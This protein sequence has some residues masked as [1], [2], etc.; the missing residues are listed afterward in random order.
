ML[1]QLPGV[2]GSAKLFMMNLYKLILIIAGLTVSLQLSAQNIG[3]NE[4]GANPHASAILDVSSVNK[5]MLV[6]RMSTAQRLAIPAPASGLLVYDTSTASFWFFDGTVWTEL[7]SGAIGGNTLDQAYDEGGP[8]AGSTIIANS[9]SVRIFGTDGIIV[10]GQFNSGEAIGSPGPGVRMFFNPRKAAFRSGRINTFQWDEVNVGNYSAAMGENVVASGSHAVAFGLNNTSSG[11]RSASFGWNTTSSGT[12]SMTWGQSTSATTTAAT[13]WG[14]S[15]EASGTNSTAWGFQTIASGNTSTAFGNQVTAPSL[16]EIAI[17]Q[18]N[19]EYTP[20]SA[21]G[22]NAA[23]RLFVIGN[24]TSNANRQNAVTVLKGG[25]VGIGTAAPSATLHIDGTLRIE[26]G[27]EAAGRVLTS[28]ANGNATWVDPGS[29]GVTLDQA[30]DFGGTG[31]GRV[32][33]ADAGAVSVQGTD[34]ME[35]TGTFNSGAAIGNPGAGTRMFFNPRKSAFRAGTVSGAQWNNATVGNYSAAFGQNTRASGEASF[36]AGSGSQANSNHSIALGLNN[37][38]GSTGAI[39]IGSSNIVSF[40]G[41]IALGTGHSVGSSYGVALGFEHTLSGTYASAMGFQNTA[42]GNTAMSF[43]YETTASANFATA[44]GN[45]TT[46]S[47]NLSTAFGHHTR[48]ESFTSFVVGRYN[49][50]GGSATAWV[51]TDPIFEVGIG[52]MPT[53]LNNAL[54]VLKNGNTGIGTHTPSATLHVDGSVRIENG[55][56]AAGHVLTSDADGNATWTALPASG[57]TLD[58]AYDFGGAGAGRII[59]AD[60][61]AVWVEGND[62]F[63]VSG[64]FASGAVIGNPG[65]GTRM[66]FNPR[67]A[68]FRAGNVSGNQWNGPNVGDYSAAFGRSNTASGE[69]SF[70][71]GNSNIASGLYSVTLGSFNGSSGLGSVTI[72]QSN[73]ADNIAAFA[74][75]RE[76]IAS[77]VA[78]VA[79]GE[80]SNA[81]GDFSVALGD[82]PISNGQASVSMGSSTIANGNNSFASGQ[83]SIANG[84]SS[85]SFGISTTADAF[86]T[87]AIGRFNEGG[88]NSNVWVATDPLFEVGTGTSI[89]NRSNALTV[90]KNGNTGIGTSSPEADLHVVGSLRYEDGQEVAGRT[91]ITDDDGNATW[92]RSQGFSANLSSNTSYSSG[93]VMVFDFENYNIGGNYDPA[94]GVFTAPYNGLYQ[95]AYIEYSGAGLGSNIGFQ[96]F[97]NGTVRRHYPSVQAVNS[98]NHATH[99]SWTMTL[100]AGETVDIRV[101]GATRTFEG[102]TN[103]NLRKTS[104]EGTF[105]K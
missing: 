68:A 75:G 94:T 16:S 17:G 82:Q 71:A 13:A 34:G 88:G 4:T 22:W 5:G 63:L 52:T 83:N 80:A 28:D 31:A 66:F 30:Y 36:A 26:I 41:G 98:V 99:I 45:N 59:T 105:I 93:N 73:L 2:S 100:Q 57:G 67:K 49:E 86:G 19:L 79:I 56:E 46:A 60:A 21:T 65:A 42:T 76:S 33:T 53:N 47:A 27:S 48:A 8:G 89:A 1:A 92:E 96:V 43:G 20:L 39:T 32:I 40:Q 10:G 55:S 15:T 70:A 102:A 95:F 23:D 74:A 91:L 103:S 64:T 44:F 25:N 97:K 69:S 9:G 101:L 3:I 29:S 51:A 85:V 18:F 78:S 81:L 61:G 84:V 77:G 87:F 54:T 38:A 58:E 12:Q 50:G 14:V 6:P 35:V 24:G 62:G 104:W 72:G 90:L 11:I 7:I 37:L